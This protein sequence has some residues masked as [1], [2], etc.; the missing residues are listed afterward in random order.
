M[1]EL[2]EKLKDIL[3]VEELD[4]NQ[5]FTDFEEWDSLSAL[6]IIALL[7]SDYEIAMKTSELREYES[8]DAF[9]K[10]VLSKSKTL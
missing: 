8:I 9:C 5:K 3:E 1:E 4:V 10:D 2:I 6:T 7:D